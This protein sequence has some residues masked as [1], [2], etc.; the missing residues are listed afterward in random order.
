MQ[1]LTERDRMMAQMDRFME[2]WDAL[3]CP[4][5]MS[6]AFTHCPQGKLIEVD[7]V[8]YP[9]TMASGAYTMPLNLT[10][11]PAIVI[12]VGKTQAGLPIGVQLVGKRWGD[13]QLLAI[14][15]TLSDVIEPTGHP[16]GFDYEAIA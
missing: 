15:Q 7:G 8:K 13:G 9:Y 3:I 16:P 6:P 1:A 5:A 2:N 14:T 12:P 10:G 11:S 4:V